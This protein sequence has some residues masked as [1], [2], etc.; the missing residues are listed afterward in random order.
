MKAIVL[1]AV[2]LL[3]VGCVGTG[4]GEDDFVARLAAGCQT[5]Q[6]CEELRDAAGAR[7][8]LCAS[9]TVSG[10]RNPRPSHRD[11]SAQRRD[12]DAAR[13]LLYAQRP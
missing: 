12:L 11:C 13:A 9:D 6:A 7:Y 1:F 8:D 10:R 2:T 4:A 5:E 3:G